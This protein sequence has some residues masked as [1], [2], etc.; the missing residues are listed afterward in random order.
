MTSA[1]RSKIEEIRATGSS[2]AAFNDSVRNSVP[3]L[4][5]QLASFGEAPPPLGLLN[6]FLT[7][8]VPGGPS[9]LLCMREIGP[10][11]HFAESIFETSFE[12]AKKS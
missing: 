6:L 5:M 7:A 9:I 1:L 3:T 2:H 4:C 8:V 12:R 10:R 11:P